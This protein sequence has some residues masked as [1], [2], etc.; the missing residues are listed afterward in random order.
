VRDQVPDPTATPSL[1]RARDALG[2]RGGVSRDLGT[3]TSGL[4]RTT[5]PRRN[6]KE[7]FAGGRWYYL[8][9][10]FFLLL[11]MGAFGVI[12]R[13]AYGEWAY[14]AGDKITLSINFLMFATGL[15]L[16]WRASRRGILAGGTLALAL[17]AFL[18]L[19]A[20]WSIDPETTIRR[21][22][23]YVFFVVGVIGVADHL[24]GDKFMDLLGVTCLLAVVAS[25]VLLVISPGNAL[26]MSGELRGIFANKNTLGPVMAAGALASLH[27]IRIGGGRRLFNIFTLIVFIVMAFAAKS[28]TSL[29]IIFAFCTADRV[30]ALFRRARILAMLL[31]ILLVLTAVIAAQSPDSFFEMIG[32]DPTLTGRTDLWPYLIPYISQR[33]M[34][35]WGF[36]A[37]WSSVNPVGNDLYLLLGWHVAHA[38]NGLLE[39]LLEVGIVG[40]IF[41][42]FLLTRNV[43]L[44]LRCLRTPA[45]DIAVSSL[46]CYGG[47]VL[48]GISENILVDHSDV[49][50]SVFFITGLICE[51]MVRRASR[52]PS[53]R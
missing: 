17:A 38:H 21:G 2:R 18:L 51:K 25:I 35:G 14:K 8:A 15:L 31:M 27:G 36:F 26:E 20:L 23:L 12:D 43:V 11:A 47:I 44:A 49:L 3:L 32:K 22:L 10:A 16:F 4:Q 30:V 28:T 46:L 6:R 50:V 1:I 33:P 19:S 9:S 7:P 29:L 42:V 34:L 13:L 40:T 37:F 45:K 41:F 53:L 39:M 48:I 24:D 5:A 52:I